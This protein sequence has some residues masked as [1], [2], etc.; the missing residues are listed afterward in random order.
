MGGKAWQLVGPTSGLWISGAIVLAAL[1]FGQDGGAALPGPFQRAVE[2]LDDP[3]AGDEAWAELLAAGPDAVGDLMTGFAADSR[4]GRLARARL[5]ARSAPAGAPVPALVAAEPDALVQAELL[6]WAGRTA[7]GEEG[8]ERRVALLGRAGR[9]GPLGVRTAALEALGGLDRSSAVAEL[10]VLIDELPPEGALAAARALPRTPRSDETL[11]RLLARGFRGKP[12]ERPPAAVL[13]ELLPRLGRR[14]AEG[15]DGGDLPQDRAP[16]VLGLRHPHPQVSAAAVAGYDAM[17]DRLTE[18]GE[19]ERTERL[20]AGLE[21]QGFD[22]RLVH[23]QRARLAFFPGLDAARALTSARALRAATASRAP[24]DAG[25]ALPGDRWLTRAQLLEGLALIALDRAAEARPVLALAVAGV[26]SRL[27][28]RADLGRGRGRFEHVDALQELALVQV[29]AILAALADGE[30]GGAVDGVCLGLAR[31]AHRA[32]LEAQALFASL[33]GEALSGWDSLLDAEISPYRL[34]FTGRPQDQLD[35]A[36]ILEL[37]EALGRVLASVSPREMPG[38]VPYPDLPEVVVNPLADPERLALLTSVQGRQLE[39][40]TDEIDRQRTWVRRLQSSPLWEVPEDALVDLSR[41]DRRRQMMLWQRGQEEQTDQTLLEL[42]VPGAMA[43]WLARDLLGEGDGPASRE[44]AARFQ[45]DLQR[46]G[47]SNW[48]YYLGQERLARADIA[49]GAA[50]TDE[51]EPLQAKESL[52]KAVERLRSIEDQL[53]ENGAGSG[54]LRPYRLLRSTA[55]V[56]LAVNANVK[57]SDPDAALA[58]YEEA[59][60]LRQD[61]FMRVLLAC[62]RARS[63][64]AVEARALLREVRPGP[65]TWYNLACTHALLG[66]TEEALR[67]L[68]TEL[69]LNHPSP[70]SLARQRE[71]ARDDPDLA[72]LREDPRFKDLVQ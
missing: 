64:R 62:Y 17:L 9:R 33:T 59:Y 43:L 52:E 16:L 44:V 54:A 66:E 32:S 41:L 68:E 51:D 49:A 8:L 34:L 45:R 13:A 38:F 47:I 2:A 70:A 56:S 31:D 27:A 24:L 12:E 69:E 57:L 58:Y 18:L 14:L 40:V 50:W 60:S 4:D 48:W 39:G 19:F 6:A 15:Q 22:P 20:L 72:S 37:Q 3:A 36:R 5:I 28:V 63:G 23:F 25:S 7:L 21:E 65:A 67:W 71:W 42:R 61:D 29:S 30:D 55:L 1:G 10:E 35:G 53:K 26:R 46:G 11:R